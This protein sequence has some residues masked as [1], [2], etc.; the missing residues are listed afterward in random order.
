MLHLSVSNVPSQECQHAIL[1]VLTWQFRGLNMASFLRE[2]G[3][4]KRKTSDIIGV[5]TRCLII[6][7]LTLKIKSFVMALAERHLETEFL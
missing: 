5:N 3:A 1:E 6:S 2:Y 7:S 4:I